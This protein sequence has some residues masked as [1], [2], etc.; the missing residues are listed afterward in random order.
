[1]WLLEYVQSHR[2][3]ACHFMDRTALGHVRTWG[4]PAEG[5]HLF[6]VVGLHLSCRNNG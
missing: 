6:Q 2:W 1:M 4:Q 3:L 5:G